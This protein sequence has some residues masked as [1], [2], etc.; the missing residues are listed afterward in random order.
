MTVHH[1]MGKIALNFLHNGQRRGIWVEPETFPHDVWQKLSANLY[2]TRLP[3]A[4]SVI[5]VASEASWSTLITYG[6]TV[7][8]TRS[9]R[10]ILTGQML[11]V[12]EPTVD[13]VLNAIDADECKRLAVPF[14]PPPRAR[15]FN[16]MVAAAGLNQ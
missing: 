2:K 8:R 6:D 12:S 10:R 15:T 14:E 1:G 9:A 7:C 11:N 4:R 13:A 3:G 5:F 16:T